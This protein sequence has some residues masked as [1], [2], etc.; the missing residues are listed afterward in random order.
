MRVVNTSSTDY[1]VEGLLPNTQYLFTVTSYNRNGMSLSRSE[2]TETT[3]A[4]VA[5]PQA[6]R[7]LRAWPTSHEAIKVTWNPPNVTNGVIKSYRCVQVVQLSV[8][9]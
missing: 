1:T 4:E 8:V 6:V 9:T 5:V 3:E 2:L 7:D